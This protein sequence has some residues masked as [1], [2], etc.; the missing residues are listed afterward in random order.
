P[1]IAAGCTMVLKPAPQTPLSSLALA[2]ILTE[3]GLPEGVLNIVVT[4]DAAG[5]VEPLLRGGRIRKLSFTGSTQVGRILLAQC[6]DTVIRT[7]ME[8]GGNAPLIVF[9][10]ADLDVAVEGTMVAKMRNMGESCCAANRI[11]VHASVAEEF[12]ARL[13]ARMAALEVGPGTE[14]GTDVGPL[15]D[16][17]ARSKADDLVHDAVKRGAKV[18]TGGELP[19]GPGCFYPPTVLTDVST[20][21]A[22]MDTE[23][24][25]PV[26]AILTFD[27]EDE[28]VTAAN[29]TE[30]G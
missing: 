9:D 14:P 13:T 30:F 24:F 27:D 6:A 22:I 25:G 11:Y 17:A 29:N 4:S 16:Q 7:S 19:D 8:L 12:A 21:A 3:A 18:L 20:D 5:V 2:E 1:A 23:I 10:D 15:I 26:A 28:A